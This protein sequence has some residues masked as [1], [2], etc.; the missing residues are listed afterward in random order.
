MIGE[1]DHAALTPL[2]MN[3]RDLL[4]CG[5]GSNRKHAHSQERTPDKSFDR[6]LYPPVDDCAVKTKVDLSQIHMPAR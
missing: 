5:R 1:A 4:R 3:V 6:H 2:I